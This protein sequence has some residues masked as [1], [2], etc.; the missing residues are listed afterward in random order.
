MMLSMLVSIFGLWSCDSVYD[1]PVKASVKTD[2]DFL[3]F[4]LEGGQQTIE[5]TVNRAWNAKLSN[6]LLPDSTEWCS[7]SSKNGDAG[8]Q[9]L[10]ITVKSMDGDY[11]EALLILNSS[12]TG[13]EIPIMQSGKPIVK[14]ADSTFIDEANVTLSGAWY[15]SGKISMTEIGFAIAVEPVSTDTI[16]TN[17][18]LVRDSISQ[19]NFSGRIS[20]LLSAT[21]YL[22]KAY[23]KTATGDVYFGIV[24][25][26]TTDITPVHLAIKDLVARAKALSVGGSKGLTESEYIN[27][28]VSN[29]VEAVNTITLSLVDNDVTADAAA[30]KSVANYGITSTIKSDSTTRGVYKTGDVLNIRIKGGLLSNIKGNP[31]FAIS[32]LLG[33]TR[34]STGSVLNANKVVHTELNNYLAM[35][36]AIDNTQVTKPY[37]DNVAYPSWGTK[38]YTM[39]V[40]GSQDSYL[41]QLPFGS[42]FATDPVLTGSGTLKGIVA[43]GSIGYLLNPT[44]ASDV[45]GLTS[46]RFMSLLGLQFL[47]PVFNG[48][49]TT[50]QTSTSYISIPYKNG[51]G[52][53]VNANITTTISGAGAAGLSVSSLNNP[54]VGNGIGSL[55]LAVFGTPTAEGDVTFTINGLESFNPSMNVTTTVI[56]PIVA[57]VGNFEVVWNVTSGTQT[58]ITNVLSNPKT[59]IPVSPL[60]AT[61]FNVTGANWKTDLGTTGLDK[62][63]DA[64]RLSLPSVYLTTTLTVPAGK[65]LHLSGLDMTCRTLGLDANGQ[66]SKVSIQYSFDGTTF[67]EVDYNT[68]A[69]KAP[70]TVVLAKFAALTNVAEGTTITF[71]IVP[72]NNNAG[73]KWGIY[74]GTIPPALLP[75]G[76]AI[77]GDV[78]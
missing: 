34:T 21:K 25:S 42:P 23:V 78:L 15:Y 69:T 68:H 1:L 13:K 67:T 27:V 10:T 14:T 59:T 65:T 77:Y 36:V 40:N 29:V 16:Y 20:N 58:S 6:N 32:N 19:G 44:S 70:F 37:L 4:G 26:F 7:I 74:G 47:S 18:K 5:L 35:Y 9:T 8:K 11:R 45:A 56:K 64:N 75:R 71:R 39:E 41:M 66:E 57:V 76:L 30:G 33:I 46:G 17:Y 73:A 72:V 61:N 63:T 52:S 24:K 28:T 3:V 54:T 62:N 50:G 2:K 48:A 49:L 31:L 60:V 22:Y 12:A 38:L 55:I 43:V 51:D 53:T